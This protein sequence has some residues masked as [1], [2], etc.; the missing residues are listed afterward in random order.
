MVIIIS[1]ASHVG[2]TYFA[3]KMLEKYKYP[4]LSIDHLK[5]GLI[6]SKQTDL[7]VFD[8]EKL[9]IYLWDIVK[10]MIKTAIE[11]N[12]NLIVEGCYVPFNYKE[13]F[14]DFY[15]NQ[16]KYKCLIFSEKYINDNYSDIIKTANVIEKRIDDYI[17]K[18]QLIKENKY[19][20]ENS[21][22]YNNEFVLIDCDY[23][24]TIE[25]QL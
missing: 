25:E 4:Y 15:L 23:T 10:E 13:Y 19:Y 6:R 9:T 3:Q 22:K 1:G 12:Q 8:D 11:N 17:S 16:I 24:K 7:T 2:K 18:E 14:D 21:I 5:M 20:M